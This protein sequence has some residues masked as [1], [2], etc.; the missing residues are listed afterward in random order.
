MMLEVRDIH[1]SFGGNSVLRGVSFSVG[2]GEILGIIG[3]NGSGKTTLI[4]VISG[5]I[6]EDRGE[7]LLRGERINTLKP[8][9]RAKA[10]LGRTFQIT[11]LFSSLSVLENVMIPL[12]YGGR[13]RA[14]RE[15]AME[16]ISAVG[17]EHKSGERAGGLSLAQRKRLELARALALSPEV[18]LL[19]EVFAGLNPTS[20]QEILS[21]LRS[22][23]EER[24]ITLVL[25]E[26]VLKAL[27]KLTRRVVV[28]AEGRL[29]YEGDPEGLKRDEKVIRAYLGERYAKREDT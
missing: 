21:L 7:I 18:L 22:I 17:L 5:V 9:Q 27:F 14:S 6:R 26:H 2:K 29:I 25:E 3:P 28:L 8:H 4:N 16:L 15:R 19:D 23:N 12:H 11:R 13:G 24:K 1:K 10:G 20:I